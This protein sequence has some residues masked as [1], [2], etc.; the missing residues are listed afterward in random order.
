MEKDISFTF[1]D[2]KGIYKT[3]KIDLPII[4]WQAALVIKTCRKISKDRFDGKEQDFTRIFYL[5][6]KYD[7]NPDQGYKLGHRLYDYFKEQNSKLY[8]KDSI[9]DTGVYWLTRHAYKTFCAY[10]FTYR[11]QD[12]LY[13]I[14]F[15]KNKWSKSS[16]F[17]SL[18]LQEHFWSIQS[19]KIPNNIIQTEF[20]KEQIQETFPKI[21]SSMY[22]K[23]KIPDNAFDDR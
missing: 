8:N 5:L 13:N 10:Q 23:V 9:F 22:Q 6:T 20:T 11:V 2:A 7:A 18:N 14:Y 3:F 17:L 21:P 12:N 16:S 1:P 19:S 15:G 4:P